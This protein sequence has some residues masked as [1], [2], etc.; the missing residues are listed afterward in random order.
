MA[1]PVKATFN[2]A[3]SGGEG[4]VTH[5]ILSAVPRDEIFEPVDGMTDLI[6]ESTTEVSWTKEA[7]I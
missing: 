4:T 3:T 7:Q 2:T 6:K 1:A 5:Y